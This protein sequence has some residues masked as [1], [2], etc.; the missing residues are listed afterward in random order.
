MHSIFLC[1]SLKDKLFVRN[2]SQHLK[3]CGI[4]A[5]IDEAEIKIG[6]SLTNVIGDAISKIDFFGIV[7]S[8][9][10]IDS[11]WVQRELQIALQREF[12]ERRVVVLPLLIS[13]VVIPPFLRDKLY[14]DFRDTAD[15]YDSLFL[16]LRALGM[17]DDNIARTEVAIH[18]REDQELRDLV[19][20]DKH[21]TK[22]QYASWSKRTKYIY[23]GLTGTDDN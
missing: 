6:Q 15:F 18:Q 20:A 14:A 5:W 13:D 19:K 16:L 8:R 12:T 22:E 17:S 2:L 10:S 21:P 7:L 23:D 4:H 1:H 9:N 11:E 3:E